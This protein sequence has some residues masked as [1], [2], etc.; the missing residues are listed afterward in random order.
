MTVS[1]ISTA[2]L[3]AESGQA[4]GWLIMVILV[5]IHDYGWMLALGGLAIA[6][7]LR[8]TSHPFIALLMVMISGISFLL[9]LTS[10]VLHLEAFANKERMK[11]QSPVELR[12]AQ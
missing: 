7:M 4:L 9:L 1:P 12:R 8:R 11:A 6:W 10:I 5:L 2:I 3:A